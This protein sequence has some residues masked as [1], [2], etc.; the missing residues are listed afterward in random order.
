[1]NKQLAALDSDEVAPTLPD[2]S[3]EG[4][5]FYNFNLMFQQ[6]LIYMGQT[7]AV[8]SP[9]PGAPSIAT[10]ATI[11]SGAGTHVMSL[12]GSDLRGSESYRPQASMAVERCPSAYVSPTESPFQDAQSHRDTL[13]NFHGSSS[14]PKQNISR[15]SSSYELLT[16]PTLKF[17]PSCRADSPPAPSITQ[18]SP[19]E[20]KTPPPPDSSTP[21]P[22]APGGTSADEKDATWWRPTSDSYHVELRCI[23][24][25]QAHAHR[26]T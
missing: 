22:P 10:A 24:L 4:V 19:P 9:A 26:G 23:E 14:T 21:S 1:M 18:P 12:E 2:E 11:P 13:E 5:G 7:S 15:R 16:Q 8:A 20:K 25:I 6:I 3:V 17:S